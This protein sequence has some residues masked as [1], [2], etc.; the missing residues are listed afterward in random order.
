VGVP[1]NK[2]CQEVWARLLAPTT[3]NLDNRYDIEPGPAIRLVP[4]GQPGIQTMVL[5]VTSLAGVEAFVR[6]VGV[7]TVMKA[8]RVVLKLPQ[9]NGLMLQLTE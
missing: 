5:Q 4:Q 2:R 3:L 8:D 9:T 1:A 7:P 6:R